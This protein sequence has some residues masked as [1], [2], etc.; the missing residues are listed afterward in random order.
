[1]SKN[2]LVA[3]PIVDSR[4]RQT[5]VHKRADN[6]TTTAKNIPMVSI[7]KPEPQD[8]C[9]LIVNHGFESDC[10]ASKMSDSV[11]AKLMD[12]LN[13]STLGRMEDLLRDHGVST[14]TFRT[15]TSWCVANRN[16]AVLN[17]FVELVEELDDKG[18]DNQINV[19]YSLMGVQQSIAP[20]QKEIDITNSDDP[21]AE[22]GRAL[23]KAYLDNIETGLI[24]RNNLKKG[25]AS[26]S[27]EAPEMEAFIMEHPDRAQ[28]I[29]DFYYKRGDFER[30]LFEEVLNNDVKAL[31]DGIL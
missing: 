26:Y 17:G 31:S 13:E 12:T 24:F 25:Q 15:A 5:T 3:T 28:D 20:R 4:G 27:F 18:R 6:G 10:L 14:I 21:R 30:G 22:G 23:A 8:N 16:F 1:M 29:V 19:L 7:K 2:P 11:R 9:N